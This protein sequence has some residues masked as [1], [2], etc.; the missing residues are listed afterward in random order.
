MKKSFWGLIWSSFL[1]VRGVPG[2]V[3]IFVFT[4]L[5]WLFSPDK[6]ISLGW[7]LPI[8]LFC[9][10][11]ILTLGNAAYEAFK[12]SKHVLPMVLVGKKPPTQF[13]GAKLL[14][15]I[16]P[17]EL[18]SYDTF[19]SFYYIGDENFEQL[20]GIGTVVNIQEDNK[21]QVVMTC[22]LDGYEEKIEK[23]VQNDTGIL[24]RTRVKPN[25]PAKTYLDRILQG[26]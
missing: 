9:V 15:L 21:I 16:E 7:V 8:G 13:S 5:I 23:L 17:S 22:S 24:K 18:F 4:V 25:I 19:V 26:E 12:I 1:R 10:I 3:I 11:L 6:N 2:G 20:M 14:C